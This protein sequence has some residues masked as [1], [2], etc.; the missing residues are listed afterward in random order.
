MK[1]Y[2]ILRPGAIGD[3]IVTL[4][5]VQRLRAQEA[6]T[7]IHLVVGA[8]AA[9]LLAGRCAAHVVESY[10]L[11]RWSGLF[12]SEMP[13]ELRSFLQGWEAIILYL[14]GH[15]AV[16]QRVA[17]ACGARVIVWPPLPS[18]GTRVT[19]AWHLQGALA[20]LG[21]IPRADPPCVI[22]LADDIAFAERYWQEHGLP[23]SAGTPV[24]ALH[25]GS[26]SARKN[27][28]AVR[29]A[30]LAT[31]LHQHYGAHILAVAGPADEAVVREMRHAWQ[32]TPL[33][34]AQN[35][36]LPEVAALLARCHC[37]IG[38]DSGIAH[39]AAALGVPTVAL[40]GP[41]D[42][43]LWAPAGPAVRIVS[44]PLAEITVAQVQAAAAALLHKVCI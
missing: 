35:L 18:A 20:E 42:P 6:E 26:G 15:T 25:P 2:L 9:A 44:A 16:A 34:L 8:A 12:M 38:N 3:A 33:T 24:I 17:A 22:L 41:T 32:N 31:H 36:T 29:Y 13:A 5:T 37:F 19:V 14:S 21:L 40:F 28:P 43:A 23:R 4:P 11:P 10:E 30:A 39:L 27:W 1:R 7:E